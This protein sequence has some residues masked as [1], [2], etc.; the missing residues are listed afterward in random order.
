MKSIVI[1]TLIFFF[2]IFFVSCGYRVAYCIDGKVSIKQKYFKLNR[3]MNPE[4][5][6]IIDTSAIY[7][8]D[9]YISNNITYQPRDYDYNEYLK[10]YGNGSFLKIYKSEL[11]AKSDLIADSNSVW[12]G[13]FIIT[14]N[15]ITLEQ[16]YPRQ[17]P[18]R[19]YDRKVL[20]GQIINQN[21]IINWDEGNLKRIYIK[22]PIN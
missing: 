7:R 18:D 17:A 1:K 16:F 8:L 21:L 9:H 4:N 22:Q 10:F 15:A 5:F 11:F 19:K 12:R 14:G 2:A 13:H 20:N 3:P 6:N